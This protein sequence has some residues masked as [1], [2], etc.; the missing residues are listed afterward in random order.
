MAD[1]YS[2][3]SVRHDFRFSGACAPNVRQGY[4]ESKLLRQKNYK[5]SGFLIENRCF[6]GCGGRI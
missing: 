2:A 5:N 1:A 3:C 6:S 4:F